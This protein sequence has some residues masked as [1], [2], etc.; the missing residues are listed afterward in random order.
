MGSI[1]YVYDLTPDV[2]Y[3]YTQQGETIVSKDKIIGKYSKVKSKNKY[4]F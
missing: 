3:K 2:N 4:R 1:E